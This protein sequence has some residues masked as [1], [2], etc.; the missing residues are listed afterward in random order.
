MDKGTLL[1]VKTKTFQDV[2]GECLYEVVAT[3]LP[4]P[5]KERKAAGIMDGV[6][7]VMLGGSGPAARTGWSVIDSEAAIQ[8][9]I[10]EGMTV[11]VPS[12]QRDSLIARYA[13]G[14]KKG[15]NGD[16]IRSVKHGGTGVVEMG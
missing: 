15:K 12:E 5:E 6:K 3:G 7:C 10:K 2:C 1:K 4:A 9:N 16:S 14:S 13:G 8:R 11:I